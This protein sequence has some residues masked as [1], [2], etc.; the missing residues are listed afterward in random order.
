MQSIYPVKEIEPAR[1][2]TRNKKLFYPLGILLLFSIFSGCMKTENFTPADHTGPLAVTAS[3]SALQLNEA[4]K[5]NTAVT[6][7]WSTGSNHLS[8]GSITYIL[9][10]DK[11]GNNF[12]TSLKN[13]L[14]K[15]IY[16]VNYATGTL[17]TLISANW[18][19][20]AGTAIVLE[21]R[22]YT[23]I[24]DGSTKGD[25]SAPISVSITPYKPVSSTLY[26]LGDATANGWTVATADSLTADAEVPGLFHYT[27][28][29]TP[30]QFKFLTSRDSLLPS[31][32][33]GTDTAHLFYRTSVSDPD[34]NFTISTANVYTIDVNLIS[35]S[36]NIAKLSAPLYSK[37]WIVGDATPNGW[38]I[39]APNEMKVDVFNPYVFHY[40]EVLN[41]GEFKMP[42]TTG[43]WGG[44]FYRPLTNHPPIT[45]TTAAL[46]PGNTNPPDNKWQISTAGPY[47]ISLN[48]LYNS[49]H[50]TPYSPYSSLWLVGDATPT[51]WNIDNPTPMTQSGSNPYVFTYNGPLTAGEFK[52]PVKTGDFGCDYFR[53]EKNH[54]DISDNNAPFVA[55]ASGDADN[56]DYKWYISVAGN[57]SITFDQLHETISI[58]K[59]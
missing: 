59:Q 56:N 19:A 22:I 24:G 34:N 35:L 46:V 5:N 31:Y 32:N 39:D 23:M 18:S 54:P 17:N 58:L 28:T 25:T 43:N 38:N 57:Y 49:I 9:E 7:S 11:K 29:L 26:I 8:D 53:P 52:I 27:G 4:D 36:I 21:A 48:I 1:I 41:A 20:Q 13:N 2:Y 16:S 51:G 6:F 37:L 12:S 45:D 14:G 44:D 33:E 30:G 42:T 50:I 47:K 55:H 3:E 15:G 40:N 10:L